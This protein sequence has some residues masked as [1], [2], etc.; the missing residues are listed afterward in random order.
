M[1]SFFPA[2]L[3]TAVRSAALVSVAHYFIFHEIFLLTIFVSYRR[4][5]GYFPIKI[6]R[7]GATS[8]TPGIESIK[9]HEI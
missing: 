8:F 2:L 9:F 3:W 4:L 1:A 7:F 6:G 5:E